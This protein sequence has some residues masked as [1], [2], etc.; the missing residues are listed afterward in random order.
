MEDKTREEKRKQ[1]PL[2]LSKA[3]FDD[4][5]EWAEDDFRSMNSQIEYILSQAVKKRKKSKEN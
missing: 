5:S 2:R 3:L 1:V 4:L